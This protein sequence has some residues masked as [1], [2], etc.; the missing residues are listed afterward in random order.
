MSL[1]LLPIYFPVIFRIASSCK[2]ELLCILLWFAM[3]LSSLSPAVDKLRVATVN[4]SLYREQ[5]GALAD[6]LATGD[7]RQGK[8]FAS[9]IQIVRPDIVLINEIDFEADQRSIKLLRE[10]YLAVDQVNE[11]GEA[12]DGIDYPYFF[13]APVNTGVDSGID[14]GGDGQLAGLDDNWGFGRYPG[15]YGMVVLSRYP[16][17]ADTVRTFQMLRWSQMP[18][19]MQPVNPETNEPYYAQ[20]VWQALRL[21]SKSHW[22]LPVS[23]DG[24]LLHVLASHPTPPAFDGPEK[25][26]GCRNHDE[27]RF[28]IDY[29]SGPKVS[30]WIVDDQGTP[31]GLDSDAMFV[32]V[33]DLNS[34]PQDGSGYSA[35]IRNL[36]GHP[37]VR[38]PQPGS[39]G[40]LL[41][42]RQ[43]AGRNLQHRG[44]AALDTAQ[45][46][47][48]NVGNLRV[49]YC[50]PSRNLELLSSEVFWPVPGERGASLMEVS[51]HRLVWIDI[52]LP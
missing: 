14:L 26:N 28:W 1:S 32:I 9:L 16:I 43:L 29:L 15:Q 3:G 24:K 27:I 22:D 11:Q 42:A 47:P 10:R 20:E 52:C 30:Q 44:N 2:S 51:D 45:F 5:I 41:A 49:D 7:S 38:D 13:A 4:G 25:R 40:A 35:A 50:L 31:G 33:G 19:A 18:D 48:A 17:E 6:E 21:S 12:T 8:Q 34:D 46:D 23:I 36:L 37:R 39:R